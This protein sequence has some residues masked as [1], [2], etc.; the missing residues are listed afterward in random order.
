MNRYELNVAMFGRHYCKIVLPDIIEA[1]AVNKA[2]CLHA[3]L[4]AGCPASQITTRLTRYVDEGYE[5]HIG[6]LVTD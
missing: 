1:D 6:G 3:A 4:L 5:V 2:R